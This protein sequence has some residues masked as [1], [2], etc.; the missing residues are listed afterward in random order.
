M[1]FGRAAR[2]HTLIEAMVAMTLLSILMVVMFLVYRTGAVAWKAG[3]TEVQL[4]QAAQL[5]TDRI[6]REAARSSVA[7][8]SLDPPVAPSTAVA[9]L[10][11]VSDTTGLPD[12]SASQR[13]PV[14]HSYSIFAYD[15][16]KKEIRFK[17]LDLTSP[18]TATIPLS[19]L[20]V[21]RAGGGL[22]AGEVTNCEFFTNAQTLSV[23]LGL[24]R[25]RY[26]KDQPDHFELHSV[27]VFRN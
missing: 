9:F 7:S 26:G 17:S 19:T 12:Y 13:T 21:D 27:V 11:L 15:A 24:E 18:Q 25:K 14:W 22:L 5:V 6:A 10:S 16:G 4:S 3:E 20:D 8:L 23:Q 2:G 1:S